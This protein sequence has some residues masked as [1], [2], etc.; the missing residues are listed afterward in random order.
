[1]RIDKSHIQMSQFRENRVGVKWSSSWAALT[2]IVLAAVVSGCSSKKFA[3]NDD[4]Q[5][6]AFNEADFS[7]EFAINEGGKALSVSPTDLGF[8]KAAFG[9][10]ISLKSVEAVLQASGEETIKFAAVQGVQ[11]YKVT[12]MQHQ[13]C[14]PYQILPEA[15]EAM[16]LEFEDAEAG[17]PGSTILG[18]YLSKGSSPASKDQAVTLVREDVSRWTIIH[19]FMHHLFDQARRIDGLPLNGDIYSIYLAAEENLKAVKKELNALSNGELPPE[20]L[21]VKA[22]QA[23]KESIISTRDYLIRYPL[24]EMAIES[25]MQSGFK[26]RQLGFVPD[27]RS[28]SSRYVNVSYLTAKN[29]LDEL[30]TFSQE[31]LVQLFNGGRAAEAKELKIERDA[32]NDLLQEMAN[33]NRI[34]GQSQPEPNKSLSLEKANLSSVTAAGRLEPTKPVSASELGQE[35]AR[36]GCS[37][38]SHLR[39]RVS[40]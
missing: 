1:M 27:R 15:N 5:D 11:F 4:A 28:S 21:L 19:E 12:K 18:L 31:L 32:S 3:P 34:Y 26:S 9:K 30:Q 37:H 39:P 8:Q 24:E 38:L 35:A 6:K 23:T 22:F 10:S 16:T 29:K 33:L 40:H 36:F 2:A 7:C 25:V 20:A 17:F 14:T 13:R